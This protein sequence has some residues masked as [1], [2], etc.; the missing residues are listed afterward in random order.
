[1]FVWHLYRNKS[2]FANCKM[3][4]YPKF[5]KLRVTDWFFKVITALFF[6]QIFIISDQFKY[7]MK[8]QLL[9]H[10]Y[11][12]I[13]QR[14]ETI[15]AFKSL[16]KRTRNVANIDYFLVSGYSTSVLCLDTKLYYSLENG[17]WWYTQ[18]CICGNEC[19]FIKII[20]HCRY[21]ASFSKLFSCFL[22]S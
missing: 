22:L 16:F 15:E 11:R 19:P 20:N 10:Y 14:S 21:I 13:T 1:M 5:I 7:W 2:F 3:Y 17:L 8:K 9:N 18:R 6:K 4:T 12:C